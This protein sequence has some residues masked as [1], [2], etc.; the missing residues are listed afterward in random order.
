MTGILGRNR[1]APDY[2]TG[3]R[4]R[5]GAAAPAD[6]APFRPDGFELLHRVNRFTV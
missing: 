4:R 5:K 1:Q 6:Q 2:V 3:P